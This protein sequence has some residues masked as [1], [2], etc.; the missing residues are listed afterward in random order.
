MRGL[1][2]GPVARIAVVMVAVGELVLLLLLSGVVP[3]GPRPA[4]D[5]GGARGGEKS[6]ADP[7][8]DR[9]SSGDRAHEKCVRNVP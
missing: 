3:A 2:H 5:Q 9:V 4:A 7:H 6:V 1:L 8:S